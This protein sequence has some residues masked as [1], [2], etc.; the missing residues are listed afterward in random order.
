MNQL[1]DPVP[2]GRAGKKALMLVALML[3]SSIAPM[4][5]LPGVSAHESA[6]DTIW[7]KSGSNDTGWVQLDAVMGESLQATAPWTLEFAP[8]ADLSNVSFQVRV[9]GSDGLMIEEPLLIA[10]DIGVSLLDWRGL[11]MLGSADSFVGANP[12]D[13]RLAPNS[14][15]GATWT[16]PSDAEITDLVIEALAPVDP[17]V[18]FEPI[19]LDIGANV[20]HPGDGRM[21]L[22][23]K[24]DVI[25]LDYNNDPTIIDMIEFES[26]VLDMEIDT[27]N[28]LIHFLTAEDGFTALSLVDSSVQ[29]SLPYAT[30]PDYLNFDQFLI[31]S[32]GNVYA[33]N[34]KGVAQWDGGSWTFPATKSTD[35]AALAMIELDAVLYISFDDEGVSRYGVIQQGLSSLSS[36]STAN[37]LHS[38][39]VTQFMV[40]GNQLLMASS[41]AGL[42]RYDWSSGFW[43][44][45]WNSGNWLASDNVA[46]LAQSGNTLYIL[47]GD[48]I[49]TYNTASNVFSGSQTIDSFRF[50]E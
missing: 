31:A 10:N 34:Q 15:S 38:D 17:A 47:N 5:A 28:N 40:S 48:S 8:G 42:A 37:S 46:G 29:V 27:A 25:I 22:A 36:W 13:G 41:D 16:L 6:T 3:C 11:G 1:L 32:N 30:N 24:D 4:M 45:T 23:V 20:I 44:S 39:E 18:S 19:Q 50:D 33:A 7:P 9:N 21:Y 14:D 43:L 35:G 2:A 49:H 26:D 12:Y